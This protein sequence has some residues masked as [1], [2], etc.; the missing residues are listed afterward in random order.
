VVVDE[1]AWGGVDWRW[2][3][4]RRGSDGITSVTDGRWAAGGVGWGACREEEG[5]QEEE[6]V[7]RRRRTTPGEGHREE[8]QM[9]RHHKEGDGHALLHR[10]TDWGP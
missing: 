6:R 8:T 10:V 5:P 3:A 7:A 2:M 1:V 4:V 9:K